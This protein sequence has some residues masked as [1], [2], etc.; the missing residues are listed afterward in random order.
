MSGEYE[1][2][3]AGLFA[4]GGVT[5]EVGDRGLLQ[6]MLDVEAALARTLADAALVPFELAEEIAA[7]AADATSFDLEKLGRSSG[8]NGTPVPGLV[9]ALRARVSE[10]AADFV[11]VGATSQDVLDTGLMLVARR[12][13]TPLLHDLDEAADACAGLAER[14]RRTVQVGRTLLQQAVPVTFGL[15]AAGWLGGLDAAAQGLAEVRRREL[16][17]ALGGA[18]GTLAAFG[19]RGLEIAAGLAA[20]LELVEPE[21]PW[22]TIRVRPARLACAL[23]MALGVTAKI[24][25]DVILLAQTEVAEV[26]GGGGGSSAMPHKRNPVDAVAVVACAR[27]GPGLVATILASMPQEHE[28]G[29]GSWQAEWGPLL[30]LLRLAGSAAAALRALLVA[31]TVDTEKMRENLGL[32]RGLVMSESVAGAL[33]AFLGPVRA[34]EL[35]TEAAGQV[36]ERYP[37]LRDAL[38]DRPEVTAAIDPGRLEQAHSPEHYLGVADQL[39]D[40]ALVAHRGAIRSSTE[41]KSR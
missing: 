24:A 7:A 16:A 31:L 38:L 30:E 19:D 25:G 27:R 41:E 13:L 33:G 5:S 18:A 35:V 14:H 34:R 11:H 10:P 2:L 17:V 12:A 36:G 21:L 6:A 26:S 8:E 28:R 9:A 1:G 29:A 15:K 37:S 22:H 3:F 20:R 4:R 40:R 32:T 23:G 39:I